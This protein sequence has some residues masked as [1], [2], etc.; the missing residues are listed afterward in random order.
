M[1]A[2]G[3]GSFENDAALDWA[4][5]VQSIADVRR[6]FDQLKAAIDATE[7]GDAYYIEVDHASE[8]IA[9]AETVAMM[10]GRRIPDFP[11]DLEHRLADAGEVDDRLVH[12][13]RNAV[14]QVLRNSELAALWEEAVEAGGENEWH[15]EITALVDR[16]NPVIEFEPKDLGDT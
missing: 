10:M 7:H 13:A 5:S 6:P 16:L 4:A 8:L 15:G 9:A 14:C 12:Q 2:W 3:K 11:E 1:G